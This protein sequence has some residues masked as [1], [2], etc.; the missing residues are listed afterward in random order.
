[1]RGR[2]EA[3]GGVIMIGEEGS[4]GN[5]GGGGRLWRERAEGCR[6]SRRGVVWA[7][8]GGGEGGN[9]RRARS[10]GGGNGRWRAGGRVVRMVYS[11]RG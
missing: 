10:V 6:V 7:E 1:M 8:G 5:G 11:Y 9:R 4:E 2:P 3:V